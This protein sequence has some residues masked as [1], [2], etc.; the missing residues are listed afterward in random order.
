MASDLCHCLFLLWQ[1]AGYTQWQ[2]GLVSPSQNKCTGFD[3]NLCM[4]KQT[5]RP[6]YSAEW[7]KEINERDRNRPSRER[8]EESW[9]VLAMPESQPLHLNMLAYLSVQS[10]IMLN[11]LLNC[12]SCIALFPTSCRIFKIANVFHSLYLSQSMAAR[13]QVSLFNVFKLYATILILLTKTIGLIHLSSEMKINQA[14][15]L[16]NGLILFQNGK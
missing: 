3:H 6:S 15:L 13:R 14:W 12:F 16:L 10:R 8:K 9:A 11:V 1:K 5:S 7:W 2:S 4:V